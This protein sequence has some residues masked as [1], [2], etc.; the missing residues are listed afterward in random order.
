[1]LVTRATGSTHASRESVF[2]EGFR[3]QK[4]ASN[5][6]RPMYVCLSVCLYIDICRYIQPCVYIYMYMMQTVDPKS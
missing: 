3:V 5:L 6:N 2:F 1:M 4:W